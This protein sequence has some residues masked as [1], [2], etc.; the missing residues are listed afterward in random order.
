MRKVTLGKSGLEVSAVGFGGIPIQRITDAEA[1]VVIRRALELGVTFIDT[2]AGYGDSQR[3][4]GQ[5]I[6]GRR[7]GLVI[8]TKSGKASHDEIAADIERSR[9]EMGI[10]CIDLFQFHGV[11]KPEKWQAIRDEG[12]LDAVLEAR[13]AGHVAH[14]GYTS[15]NVD[16]ALQLAEE[17]LFETVQFPF[18]L[19]THEPADRLIP[20]SRE[21]NLGFIV[22]KPLCGG[23]YDDA[24]LAFRFL[25][26]YPDLVAIPGIAEAWEIE[27]IAAI[28]DRGEG[29]T[30]E[31]A[32]RARNIAEKL[33]KRFCRQCGYCMPCP[34][35]VPITAAMIFDGMLNR[36]SM[37]KVRKGPARAIAERA[38]NCTRCGACEA[39]CPYELPIMDTIETNRAKAR[40]ILESA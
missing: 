34:N 6:E 31:A 24:E 4:I 40:E 32:V 38:G 1:V 3:K 28:V 33:G 14:I 5:A 23:Q 21:R 13:Q 37:E 30:G 29:L 35:D 19:V 2:A 12:G 25:N 8:A 18:N 11:S 10:D 27:Q 26:E 20:V 22:M 17:E 39:K 15:H 36:M 7:D 9:Q 16:A